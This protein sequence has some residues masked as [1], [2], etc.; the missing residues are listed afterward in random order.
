[1]VLS[2]MLTDKIKLG[3]HHKSFLIELGTNGINVTKTNSIR[4]M[5]FTFC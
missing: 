5:K 1:M 2:T 3:L 4:M